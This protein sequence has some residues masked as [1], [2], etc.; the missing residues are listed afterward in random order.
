MERLNFEE[1]LTELQN[2]VQKLQQREVPLDE[3]VGLYRRGT[4]LAQRTEELLS[5]AELQ[6]QKLTDAVQERFAEYS[7]DNEWE[8]DE[9]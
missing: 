2:V 4:E 5:Q 7:V 1:A 8:E 6:V 3:A 9:N